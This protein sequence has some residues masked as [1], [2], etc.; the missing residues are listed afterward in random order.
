MKI[1]GGLGLLQTRDG[2]SLL[3]SCLS[4]SSSGDGLQGKNPEWG[5]KMCLRATVW[6]AAHVDGRVALGETC[7]CREHQCCL[8]GL[9]YPFSTHRALRS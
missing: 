1:G 5:R 7:G 9:C 6:L 4:P 2:P 8:L 3:S